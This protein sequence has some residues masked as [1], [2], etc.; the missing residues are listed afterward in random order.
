MARINDDLAALGSSAK[1]TWGHY[2]PEM[3][4]VAGEMSLT[5]YQN[6]ALSLR[7]A[8][9]ARFQTALLNGCNA[10]YNDRVARDL[11]S[12]VASVDASATANVGADRGTAPDE[13]M[14]AAVEAGDLSD[15]SEREQIAVEFARRI[16]TEPKGIPGDDSFWMRMHAV[17]ADREIVDLTYSITTWIA[18]GR[19][20]HVLQLDNFCPGGAQIPALGAVE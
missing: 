3:A 1:T 5:V 14:Y 12:Y 8:E 15:L 17:Y 7:E 18:A 2:Q 20:L 4:R 19:F 11:P 16:G 13:A 10:C 9:A 6:T